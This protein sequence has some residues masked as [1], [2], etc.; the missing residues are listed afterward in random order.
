MLV[1]HI[2]SYRAQNGLPPIEALDRVLEN[3]WCNLPENVGACESVEIERGWLAYIHGGIALLRQMFYR[4]VVD[5]ETADRRAA[6][7]MACPFNVFPDKV[8][9]LKWSDDI[10]E[11]SVGSKR[12]KHHDKLGNCEVCSCCLKAKV[13]YDKKNGALT[14]PKEQLELMAGVD[15]WQPKEL[16]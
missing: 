5:Q 12:A 7:C 14:F 1:K 11:Q 16:K 2:L 10:A 15:C 9:F 4:A 6:Q 3:Y 13:W 8:G